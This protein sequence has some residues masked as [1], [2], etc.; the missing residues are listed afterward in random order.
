[1]S[2]TKR[3]CDNCKKEY[4]A[5]DRNLARGWGL[6]CSKSCAA[7]KREMSKEGYSKNR[8][9]R[10][11]IKR[12][13]WHDSNRNIVQPTTRISK[14]RIENI[15]VYDDPIYDE[16]GNDYMGWDDHKDSY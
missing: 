13:F 7:K 2:H 15:T 14:K 9:E 3:N 4:M 6:C 16:A 5:D 12:A 11:N 1:M 8:V 10:N